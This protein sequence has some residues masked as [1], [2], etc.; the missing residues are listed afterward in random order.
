MTEEEKNAALQKVYDCEKLLKE[1]QKLE[2]EQKNIA[3]RYGFLINDQKRLD[4]IKEQ[5]QVLEED[6][7]RKINE[8]DGQ[9]RDSCGADY[10]YSKS[11][12]DEDLKV[13]YSKVIDNMKKA[14]Q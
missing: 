5:A 1:L 4:E 7:V 6:F 12:F 11:D 9:L 3:N 2:D 10:K 14:L 13:S 8:L